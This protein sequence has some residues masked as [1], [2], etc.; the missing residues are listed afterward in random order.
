[1]S[2]ASGLIV[3]AGVFLAAH[4]IMDVRAVALTARHPK[5]LSWTA[6]TLIILTGHIILDYVN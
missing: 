3:L 4:L 6:A 5:D 1:M 2:W